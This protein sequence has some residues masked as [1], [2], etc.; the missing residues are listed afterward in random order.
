MTEVTAAEC[1]MCGNLFLRER[2]RGKPREVC[3]DG[4][5]KDRRALNFKTYLEKNIEKHRRCVRERERR[6]EIATRKKERLHERLGTE[7]GLRERCNAY[8]RHYYWRSKD[9][10][11]DS[12]A[13]SA[14]A[15]GETASS[16]SPSSTTVPSG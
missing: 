1:V 15:A 10:A 11:S 9:G 4:C 6:P 12:A 13:R 8:S 2:G 5:H 16:G 14:A 7:P 3:S